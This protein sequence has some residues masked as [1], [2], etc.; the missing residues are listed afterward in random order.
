MHPAGSSFG[1][2]PLG[3]HEAEREEEAKRGRRARKCWEVPEDRLRGMKKKKNK[4]GVG[5]ARE[6]KKEGGLPK[7]IQKK[8]KEKKGECYNKVTKERR[9]KE[10]GEK[11]KNRTRARKLEKKGAWV[12][13][14]L[15]KRSRQSTCPDAWRFF[16]REG[17][18]SKE[19]L[20][21]PKKK[22]EERKDRKLEGDKENWLGTCSYLAGQMKEV[23]E[24][25][26][27]RT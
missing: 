1:T 8:K 22:T 10:G 15:M 9:R 20:R 13:R 4:R 6:K 2:S 24:L 7:R 14:K 21:R 25:S 27:G 3:T 18:K 26:E 12:S 16:P 17:K 23:P 11:K 5:S 19:I